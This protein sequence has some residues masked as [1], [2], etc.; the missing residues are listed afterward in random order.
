MV[1][2]FVAGG[3]YQVTLTA[4]NGCSVRVTTETIVVYPE[5]ISSFTTSKNTYCK[6]EWVNFA[7]T[8]PQGDFVWT[9]G[10]GVSSTETNP[11]HRFVTPGTYLVTLTTFVTQPDGTRCSK[12]VSKSYTVLNPPIAT[13]SSNASASNC[14]PFNL[15]VSNTS[16][17]ANKYSWY[18]DDVL[19]STHETSLNLWLYATN[20]AVKVRLVAENTEGCASASVEQTVQMS[21]RPITNFVVLPSQIIKI[22]NYTFSFQN[23]TSGAVKYYKW[24][25]GDG[26][27]ST[28]VSPTHTYKMIGQYQVN[29]IAINKEGCSDTLSRQVEVLTVPGYL[30]VPNAFEPSSQTYELKTFKN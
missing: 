7:N 23:T 14:A 22:P 8:S 13:F 5:P 10:D 6:D 21:P 19:V 9:F 17:F 28:E 4:T 20:R 24:S 27:T 25:F 3:T 30:Y 15:I 12:S 1:H 18:V 2:T 29:L 26:T 16:Q 11:Q